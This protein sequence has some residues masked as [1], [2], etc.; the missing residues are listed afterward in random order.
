MNRNRGSHRR[1]ILVALLGALALALGVI[2]FG[3]NAALQGEAA[4]VFTLFY[5]S[6]QLFVLE[7]GAVAG[8][9]PWELELARF[10]APLV[11]VL[12]A[13]E[14]LA[15]VLG[16][17]L[18]A[19]RIRYLVRDHF[20]ICGLDAK[21]LPLVRDLCERGETVVVA[22]PGLTEEQQARCQG[23]GALTLG[24]TSLDERLL[25]RAGIPRARQLVIPTDSDIRNIELSLLAARVLRNSRR[26]GR[27]QVLCHVHV[28]DLNLYTRLC[29]HCV[30]AEPDGPIDI[31]PFNIYESTAR[32]LLAHRPLDH[33][34]IP[35]GD[36][37]T[38]HLII[39][40]FGKMGQSVVLQAAKIAHF[41]NQ[42]K[43]R[44]T[45]I[46]QAARRLG[47]QFL[48]RFP[49]FDS[50]CDLEFIESDVDDPEITGRVVELARGT[51][52]LPTV[53]VCFD[54]NTRS[55]QCAIKVRAEVSATGT[56]L[57]V[58]LAES[59]DLTLLLGTDEGSSPAFIE[60]F[61]IDQITVGM[62]LDEELDQLAKALHAVYVARRKQEG[63][64]Y[65]EWEVL[66]PGLKDSNRQAADHIPVKLRAIGCSTD[67]VPGGEPVT[68]FT[69]DEVEVLAR[70]EH[71]RWT[72]ERIL[73]GWTPGPKDE[74]HKTT[75]YL[76][77]WED[78]SE[79]IRGYD[80]EPVRSIPKL[81][82]GIGK[83]IYRHPGTP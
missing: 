13:I 6:I 32:A 9:V 42:Q 18:I 81:L 73:A 36:L 83:K 64:S 58:R 52:T 41:A 7:S 33:E 40:G 19:L 44:V 10:L 43:P 27:K 4:S 1:W 2:G 66:D 39:L 31:R 57:L 78:L 45:A 59:T 21:S 17:W 28:L 24:G 23:L 62:I 80:R 82:A 74:E 49:R 53:V 55:L 22:D 5:L 3:R 12:A 20:V 75:P 16:D 25:R 77:P 72:A 65:K 14:I 11:P 69:P 50:I 38:V 67:S 76:V 15:H 48:D 54:D 29:H 35:A 56:P 63:K 30:L 47:R 60:T 8:P 61:G 26:R 71:D 51:D 70:M 46:D 34:G 37:R 68:S 79:E